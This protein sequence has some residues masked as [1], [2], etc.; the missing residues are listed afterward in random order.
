MSKS[1]HLNK[2]NYPMLLLSLIPLGYILKGGLPRF[3][4]ITLF[5]YILLYIYC[6]F[7]L[8]LRRQKIKVYKADLVPYLWAIFLVASLFYTPFQDIGM[9]KVGKF[10]CLGLGAYFFSRLIIKTRQD[11]SL[12][13]KYLIYMSVFT[14]VVV[15][16]DFVAKG[17]P[18]GRYLAFNV[19][20]PIPITMLG[21]MT[22]IVVL[23]LFF[24]KQ[25]NTMTVIFTLVPSVSVMIIGASKGPTISFAITILFFLP[26]IVRRIKLR[27]ILL[28]VPLI[29]GT[30]KIDFL[31]KNLEFYLYRFTNATEDGSSAERINLYEQALH[32]FEKNPFLGVGVNGISPEYYPH[33]I[34][35]EILA[36]NGLSLYVIFITIIFM[37]LISYIRF[38]RKDKD[39]YISAII[40]A[41]VFVSL[42]SLQFSW[43][44][45][46]HKYLFLGLGLLVINSNLIIDQ[47]EISR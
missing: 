12:F 23:L 18:L 11:F 2:I 14:E 15:I 47:K 45:V 16:A 27:Y 9:F 3:M 24:Y 41:I 8:V 43:T 26:I 34:S 35:L 33:N 19:V 28:F 1:I 39:D 21:I 4:D 36:E 20:Y 42:I 10:I 32:L 40:L 46:D 22:F 37:I 31:S 44:Y 30:F 38:I 29:W 25:I 5:V 7:E 17:A 6:A 13:F